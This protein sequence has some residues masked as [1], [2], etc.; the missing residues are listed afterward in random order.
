[1]KIELKKDDNKIM[2]IYEN[3]NQN[4]KDK[5]AVSSREKNYQYNYQ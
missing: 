3:F 1:M 5:E 2:K 4:R